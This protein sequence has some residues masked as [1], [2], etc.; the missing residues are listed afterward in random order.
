MLQD[1]R[2]VTLEAVYKLGVVVYIRLLKVQYKRTDALSLWRQQWSTTV[3]IHGPLQ[4]RGGTRCPG[5]V[6]VSCLVSRT[7]HECQQL[8]ESV[9]TEA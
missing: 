8:N 6:S 4:T 7:R 2:S 5:G 3:D 1:S 9:Y